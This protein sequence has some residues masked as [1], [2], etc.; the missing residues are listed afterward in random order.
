MISRRRF[1]E[2]L[3]AAAIGAPLVFAEEKAPSAL[4]KSLT[5]VIRAQSG[6][7]LD[8]TEMERIAKDLQESAPVLERFRAFKLT[9][10]D[11]PDLT[12][13]ALARRW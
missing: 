6:R 11:E 13:S 9:N 7:F 2:T 5:E 4:G 10:S 12:F 8:A 3:T 1:A